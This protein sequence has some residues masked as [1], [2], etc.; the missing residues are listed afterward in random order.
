M[1]VFTSGVN[2][3]APTPLGQCSLECQ[4]G[5][6]FPA[7]GTYLVT[8]EGVAL[9]DSPWDTTQ[10]QPLLDSIKTRH[11]ADVVLCIATHSHEDRT[12]GLQFLREQHVKTYTSRMTDDLCLANDRKRAEFTFEHETVFTVGQYSFLAYYGEPGH[13]VDNIVI[14]F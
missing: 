2:P 7:N 9:F 3:P 14:W 6:P 5:T 11:N 13:T 10:F 8:S 12:G 4:P 1:S